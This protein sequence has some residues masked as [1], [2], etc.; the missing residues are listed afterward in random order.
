VDAWIPGGAFLTVDWTTIGAVIGGVI[1]VLF[2]F[3]EWRKSHK[4]ARVGR[5][6]SVIASVEF[7]GVAVAMVN[8]DTWD[9]HVP[10]PPKETFDVHHSV[11]IENVGETPALDI[12]VFS[13]VDGC[14]GP[15]FE[16]SL[17]K[18]KEKVILFHLPD[19]S[20]L[21]PVA[22]KALARGKAPVLTLE[23]Q[24]LDTEDCRHSKASRFIYSIDDHKWIAVSRT[25]F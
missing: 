25:R 14:N 9:V 8:F 2:G 12:V 21:E 13:R 7:T 10:D 3:Y 23:I 6:P 20:Q 17:L 5:T 18:G 16:R 4:L 22:Q 1:G 15:Q 11:K 24:H 19:L